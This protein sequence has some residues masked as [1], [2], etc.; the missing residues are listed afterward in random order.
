MARQPI[1]ALFKTIMDVS[2]PSFNN[3]PGMVAVAYENW[4]QSTQ[5]DAAARNQ[6]YE[7][8][9]LLHETPRL[10]RDVEYATYA[11]ERANLKQKLEVTMRSDY[12]NQLVG[13]KLTDKM[14]LPPSQLHTYSYLPGTT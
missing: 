6:L 2:A 1:H 5:D 13:M 14:C 10:E 8:Y 7:A 9:M 3:E 4:K 12:L 11:N